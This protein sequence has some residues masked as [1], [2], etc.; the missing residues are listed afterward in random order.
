MIQKANLKTQEKIN[1]EAEEYTRDSTGGVQKN[2][3]TQKKINIE[4]QLMNDP[5]GGVQD[6]WKINIEEY[7]YC[8]AGGFRLHERTKEN[9]QDPA[10]HSVGFSQFW[11][12][13]TFIHKF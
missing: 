9:S 5:A 7:P 11:L 2:L 4:E 1:I 3:K 12:S 6:T 10:Q 13:D 8:P